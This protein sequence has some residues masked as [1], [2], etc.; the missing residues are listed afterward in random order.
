MLLH[1]NEA[2]L[3]TPTAESF[4]G[5]MRF[6]AILPKGDYALLVFPSWAFDQRK[7]SSVVRVAIHSPVTIS[8][9]KGINVDEQVYEEDEEVEQVFQIIEKVTSNTV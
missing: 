2:T 9:F 5:N 7:S 3:I 6:T 1:K 4:S 8:N